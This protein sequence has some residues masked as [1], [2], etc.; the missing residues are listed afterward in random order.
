MEIEIMD[1][2]ADEAYQKFNEWVKQNMYKVY[3]VSAN[4]PSTKGENRMYTKQVESMI[5][6]PGEKKQLEIWHTKNDIKSL[7][8]YVQQLV[9]Y[10][11]RIGLEQ[12]VERAKKGIELNTCEICHKPIEGLEIGTGTGVVHPDCTGR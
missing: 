11:Y 5:L 9:H 8:W 4:Q 12:N 10:A 2:I 1:N 3:C 7:I 6:D